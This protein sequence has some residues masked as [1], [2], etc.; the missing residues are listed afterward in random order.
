MKLPPNH[1]VGDNW[2]DLNC[3]KF[4]DLMKKEGEDRP[5][6]LIWGSCGAWTVC[7]STGN[8]H[9]DSDLG[10]VFSCRVRRSTSKRDW[11]ILGRMAKRIGA[12]DEMPETIRTAPD[13]SHYWIWGGNV[14][15]EVADLYAA[16]A[17]MTVPSHRPTS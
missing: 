4:I 6:V 3:D 11:H 1:H 2:S 5:G 12:P 17:R 9:G 16:T 7:F 8:K 10:N 13:L 15:K 14:P